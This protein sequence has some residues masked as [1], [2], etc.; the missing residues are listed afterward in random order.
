M[1]VCIKPSS[2]VSVSV[3]MPVYNGQA[4]LEDALKSVLDQSGIDNLEIL[5]L[6]DGSQDNSPQ[7]LARYEDP[8]LTVIRHPNIGLAAT[9]NKALSLARGKYM[10]RQDQDDLLLPGR[11]RKQLAFLESHPE[12]AIVGTW[13]EIY[14]GDTPDG[15][16][17]RHPSAS[18]ALRLQLLF[19]NP[20]VHSSIMMRADVIRALGGYSE[21]KSRQP[22]EDYEF[23][24]RIARKHAIANLPEVLTVYR[25][26][27]GSMS[28]TG[29]IGINPFLVKI[30]RISSENLHAVLASHWSEGDCLSL[31]CLYHDALG[32]PK[33]LSKHNALAMIEQAAIMIG[34]E[35][36][37]WS[38][39]MLAEVKRLEHH[40][41]ARCLQNRIPASLRVTARW[42]R[43]YLRRGGHS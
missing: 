19:D 30:L 41:V 13:A 39:E 35:H 29:V 33:L 17:H 8:R 2:Q 5:V 31:S 10:A 21:D 25:E 18:D 40:I 20:F 11:L 36:S 4:F 42:L 12:V 32:A 43:N 16:Y 23:W 7:I 27:S 9:L 24:S 26:I 15:R 6:D 34:G 3:L 14:V 22:P 28:R 37:Q 1:S 38:K